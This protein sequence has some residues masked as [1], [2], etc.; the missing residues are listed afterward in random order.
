MTVADTLKRIEQLN[1]SINAYTSIAPDAVEQERQLDEE[2]TLGRIRSP[3]HGKIISIKDLIDVKGMATTAASRVLE[4][5]PAAA[6]APV[7]ARLRDAGAII[8][9]KCNLHEF[10]LG[11]TSDE[12]AFGPTHNPRD[13]ARSA[14]GSS[15][16]SAAAVAGALVGAAPGVRRVA[17]RTRDRAGTG[18]PHDRSRTGGR[19]PDMTPPFR[20]TA[21][22]GRMVLSR[23]ARTPGC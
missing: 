7:V 9:G 1:P 12:S 21:L 20:Q 3:L 23:A 18:N 15:G 6:D 4:D 22:A 2:R 5:R 11:T 16:G 8:I 10:A 14:G 19:V 13:L 17:A